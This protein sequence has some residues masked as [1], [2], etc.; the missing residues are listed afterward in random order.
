MREGI[1]VEAWIDFI[2][3]VGFPIFITIYLL[4]R[5]ERIM[6]KVIDSLD[7]LKKMLSN[8]KEVKYNGPI[9]FFKHYISGSNPD[10]SLLWN[11]TLHYCIASNF[12]E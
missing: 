4:V 12:G 3:N 2:A 7:E 9:D 1:Y 11:F 10:F 8:D 5:L 6:A